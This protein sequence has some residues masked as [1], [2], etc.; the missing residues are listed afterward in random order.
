MIS[1]ILRPSCSSSACAIETAYAWRKRSLRT[2][3]RPPSV[4]STKRRS[5]ARR[6]RED[7]AVDD[8]RDRELAR[9]VAAEQR[10]S[11]AAFAGITQ[12][13]AEHVPRRRVGGAAGLDL[14]GVEHLVGG[15]R[16][17]PR[18][19]GGRRVVLDAG[20]R[21][22][23]R[24]ACRR[25]RRGCA[26]ATAPRGSGVPSRERQMLGPQPQLAAA[27]PPPPP[28]PRGSHVRGNL[29]RRARARRRPCGRRS[30]LVA[31]DQHRRR[32]RERGA[33]AVAGRRR[34]QPHAAPRRLALDERPRA[35]PTRP[36]RRGRRRRRRRRRGRPCRQRR[37]G[38]AARRP[39]RSVRGRRSGTSRRSNAGACCT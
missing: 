35:H 4:P 26:R 9:D 12:H 20:W 21:R 32:R 2:R 29:G 19:A 31:A 14:L 16:G 17:A 15:Q 39:A 27:P 34:H 22:G 10:H 36:P 28:P 5:L 23:S 13:L 30:A 1:R 3:S 25:A 37:C 33:R 7:E 6:R 8:P 11:A 24:A 38:A 18:R